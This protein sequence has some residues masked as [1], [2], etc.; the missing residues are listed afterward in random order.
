MK[1]ASGTMKMCGAR[2]VQF[3]KNWSTQVI[4]KAQSAQRTKL[5]AQL[6][7]NVV[8]SKHLNSDV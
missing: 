3:A 4:Y 7:L 5:R 1:Y 8:V 6:E 2:K